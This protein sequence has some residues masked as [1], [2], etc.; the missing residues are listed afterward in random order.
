MLYCIEMQAQV[1]FQVVLADI[2]FTC[3]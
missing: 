3:T 2:V 1:V